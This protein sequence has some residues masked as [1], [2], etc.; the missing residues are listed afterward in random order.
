MA[1]NIEVASYDPKKV[2]LVMNG[3]IITGFASDSMITIARNE[4]TVTTQVGVK[5]DVAYNENANESGTITV[6]LMGTSSS[7]PY[8]RSLA[9]KRKEV[10]VMIVDAND[11]VRH[12]GKRHLYVAEER[13]RVIKP[14]DITRA[15]EIGSE[16]VSI[17]VPSLNYR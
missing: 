12:H 10:S 13:C 9:L 17:F 4:D 7:L 14:P 16:S 8:V 11:S 6:T 5:G 3:K 2:N 1:S 15:K